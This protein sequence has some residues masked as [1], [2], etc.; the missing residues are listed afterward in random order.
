MRVGAFAEAKA[1]ELNAKYAGVVP[2]LRSGH[3][4][5]CGQI[6][7]GTF[8]RE[9]NW[10]WGT[11]VPND[12]GANYYGAVKNPGPG[13]QAVSEYPSIEEIPDSPVTELSRRGRMP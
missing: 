8:Q 2:Q 1:A 12:I 11:N 5:S 10:S 7:D 13:S 3:V 9:F 6:A 4:G